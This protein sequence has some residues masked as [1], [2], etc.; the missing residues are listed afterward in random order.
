[1]DN[2]AVPFYPTN[3]SGTQIN[4]FGIPA[5]K[6]PFGLQDFY[7]GI[8]HS[9]QFGFITEQMIQVSFLNPKEQKKHEKNIIHKTYVKD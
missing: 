9:T 8:R 4:M 2:P 3:Y 6:L 5:D 7:K 1:M